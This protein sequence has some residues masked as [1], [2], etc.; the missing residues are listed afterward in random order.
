[1]GRRELVS[2]SLDGGPTCFIFRVDWSMGFNGGSG[3]GFMMCLLG[4]F[5]LS[6]GKSFGDCVTFLPSRLGPFSIGSVKIVWPRLCA[7]QRLNSSF[8]LLL[9]IVSMRK[10]S[11]Y[12]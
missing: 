4:L 7:F 5:L 8:W 1:M 6:A 11:K 3:G 12:T 9:S 10:K 2:W